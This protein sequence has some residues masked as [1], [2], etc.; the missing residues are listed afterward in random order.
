M[1]IKIR[2]PQDIFIE[3]MGDLKRP[4]SFAYERVGFIF[5]KME[6]ISRNSCV[7]LV[8][9]YKKVRDDWYIPDEEVGAR[10]NAASI[11]DVCQHIL[12]T[13]YSCFHV[14]LHEFPGQARFSYTDIKDQTRLIHGFTN[15]NPNIPH[16]Q[17]LFT[18]N[19]AKARILMRN[20]RIELVD[21]IVVVGLPMRFYNV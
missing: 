17:L 10:I 20:K 16:G 7:F 5:S 11:H 3:M 13:S 4:H 12:D 21:D 6:S 9:S 2:I 19:H 18:P 15:L 14:H 8:C 1:K